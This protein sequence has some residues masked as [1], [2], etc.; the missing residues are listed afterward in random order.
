MLPLQC[1]CMVLKGIAGTRI[2]P[3]W[4]LGTNASSPPLGNSVNGTRKRTSAM[5]EGNYL[6][7]SIRLRDVAP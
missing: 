2:I 7:Q 1:W 4:M 3:G 5:A 6:K